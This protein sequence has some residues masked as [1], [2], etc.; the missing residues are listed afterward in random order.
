MVF[1]PERYPKNW[2]EIRASILARAENRCER[3][4][5]PNRALIARGCE[6]HAD[7]YMLEDGKVFHADTGEALGIARGSEYEAGSFVRVV[8]TVAHLDHVEANNDLSNLQALCQRCHLRH[9]AKD[10]ARR[11]KENAATAG[12]QQAL[13]L[14]VPR[15]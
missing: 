13:P 5:A 7:T 12:G 2:K 3:C 9:D 4:R 8:L 11:R 6:R 14:E 10:N 15:G 1:R